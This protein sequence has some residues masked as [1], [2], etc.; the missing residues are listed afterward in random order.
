MSQASENA[1][2]SGGV[3]FTI[4]DCTK[5]PPDAADV[6]APPRPPRQR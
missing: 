2:Q 3:T 1:D 6:R 4:F 5:Q